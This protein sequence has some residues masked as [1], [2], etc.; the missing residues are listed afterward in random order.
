MKKLILASQSP[1]RRE[2]MEM[3]GVPFEVIVSSKEEIVTSTDPAA[4]TE[5]LSRQKAEAVA[6]KIEE[7]IVIGADTVVASEGKILGKPADAV[8]ACRM[9]TSLQGNSHMVYTGVTILCKNREAVR[10]TTFSE[11]TKVNVAAMTEE[12]IKHYVETGEPYDKAGGYGIQGTFGRYIEGIEGDF[13]N[14]VGLPVHRVYKE[15][16]RV[17]LEEE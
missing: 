14:V 1:R 11:A 6:D 4:V 3:M 7:G 16:C 15:L 17:A 8:E 13:Y 12:E 10:V 5:E 2:L 9:I